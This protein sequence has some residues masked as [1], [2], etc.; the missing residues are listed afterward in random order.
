MDRHK[1]A[2]VI[3]ALFVI[4]LIASATSHGNSSQG[5]AASAP[6]KREARAVS[7]QRARQP[8]ATPRPKPTP[9]PVPSPTASIQAERFG[10]TNWAVLQTDADTYKGA[11]VDIVGKVFTSPQRDARG[12]YWQMWS[13]PKNSEWNT[14]V[15]IADPTFQISDG[16][17]VHVVGV[18]RGR[19]EGTNAFGADV[20]AVEVFASKA[21]VV[22][23]L[24]AATPAERVVQADQ[25]QDQN[26]VTIR[27]QRIEFAPDETRVFVAVS[28]GSGSTAHFYDFDAKAV[29][30]TTEFSAKSFTDYPEVQSDILS[31]VVSSGVVTF[32]AMNPDRDTI[33]VFQ[34]GSDNFDATFQPYRFD[35]PSAT[36]PPSASASSRSPGG[37]RLIGVRPENASAAPGSSVSLDYRIDNETGAS[38]DVRLGATVYSDQIRQDVFNDQPNDLVVTATPGVHLY[39]RPFFLPEGAAGQTFDLLVS[40]ANQS[41]T[42][43]YG[44]LRYPRAIVVSPRS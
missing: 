31:G 9:T 35:V 24:A 42:K 19:A 39:T 33:L 8:T 22:D 25:Q 43:S 29:Q 4:G 44:L 12:T 17:Y 23:A 15:A 18:V 3:L 26:G 38:Q 13:D 28:N 34:V 32:P 2:T 21:T 41:F 7:K 10:R 36:A 37:L 11:T 30:G 40:I 5:A 16:D 6:G 14:A 20:T 27:V 1:I